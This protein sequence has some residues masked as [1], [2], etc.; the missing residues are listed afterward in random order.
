MKKTQIEEPK[1]IEKKN[2]GKYIRIGILVLLVVLAIGFGPTIYDK[3]ETSKYNAEKSLEKLE[4]KKIDLD[5]EQNAEFKENGFSKK[6]YT[7]ENDI[8]KVREDIAIKKASISFKYTF[9]P[10]IVSAVLVAIVLFG[11]IINIVVSDMKKMTPAFNRLGKNF[12]HHQQVMDQQKAVFDLLNRR[13]EQEDLKNTKLKPLKC[14]SCK[15]NV[16]H[17]AKK[18]EYC[19]TSLIREKNNV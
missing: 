15:A 2:I 10:I 19:G 3:F 1:N 18:C 11:I 14:P 4:E 12:A 13:I 6:Y 5:V 7:L 17:G 16:E 9:L 8:D